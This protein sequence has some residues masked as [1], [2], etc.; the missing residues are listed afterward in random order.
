MLE[1]LNMYSGVFIISLL[2]MRLRSKITRNPR[3]VTFSA[4]SFK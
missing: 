1:K 2:V 4:E 3:A